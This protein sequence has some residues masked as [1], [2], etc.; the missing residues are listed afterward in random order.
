MRKLRLLWL[1]L[2]MI[3][4]AC[5]TTTVHN[6][7]QLKVANRNARWGVLPFDNYTQTPQAADKVSSMLTSILQTKRVTHIITYQQAAC[8]KLLGCSAQSLTTK[9]IL[10]WA[11]KNRL[12]YMI[13][14]TVNEC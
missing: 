1:L 9:N 7:V 2:P 11:R 14:G 3:L 13:K 8:D 10:S 12:S 5:G 6:G 4:A